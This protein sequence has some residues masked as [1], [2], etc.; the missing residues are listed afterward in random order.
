VGERVV[1]YGDL[2]LGVVDACVVAWAER[3]DL[4]EIAPV[5]RRHIGVARPVTSRR[6]PLPPLALVGFSASTLRP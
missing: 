2:S 3:L 5:D 4:A 1:Q 6:S